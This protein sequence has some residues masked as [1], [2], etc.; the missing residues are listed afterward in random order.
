MSVLTTKPKFL[1]PKSRMFQFD[2]VTERIVR[3]LEKRNWSV[4]GITVDFHTYGTGEAKYRIVENV[5]GENIKLYFQ[6][7]RHK[8]TRNPKNIT[9][10]E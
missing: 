8:G 3:A 9:V 2:E 7:L 4:P 1:Y 10:H 5:Y 6:S